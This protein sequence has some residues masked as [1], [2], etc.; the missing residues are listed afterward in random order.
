VNRIGCAHP[1]PGRDQGEVPSEYSTLGHGFQ[2]QIE[3]RVIAVEHYCQHYPAIG[4]FDH[5]HAAGYR[6]TKRSCSNKKI[7][8]DDDSKKSHPA[9]ACGHGAERLPYSTDSLPGFFEMVCR[10]ELRVYAGP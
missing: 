2:R 5:F 9:L 1:S 3:R 8:G 7:E 10:S 6:T 4:L